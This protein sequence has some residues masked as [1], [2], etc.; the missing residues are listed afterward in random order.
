[1][2]L[3]VNSW[4]YCE[5]FFNDSVTACLFTEDIEHSWIFEMESDFSSQWRLRV[6]N[7]MP[8][9]SYCWSSGI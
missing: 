6:I 8:S 3:R 5:L 7:S 2:I 9:H 4:S 1:M